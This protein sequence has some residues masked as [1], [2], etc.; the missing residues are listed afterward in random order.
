MSQT[1]FLSSLPSIFKRRGL[2]AACILIATVASA[3]WFA[4]ETP[5]QYEATSRLILDD[6]KSS[7]SELGREL[8]ELTEFGGSVDPIATQAELVVSQRVL[9]L[10]H[11]SLEAAG[12]PDAAQQFPA[13]LVRKNLEVSILPATNILKLTF[14]GSDPESTTL[15]L[16]SLAAAV[17]EEN[18]ETTRSQAAKVRQFL[19]DRIPKLRTQLEDLQQSEQSYRQQTGLVSLPEQTE[20]LIDSLAEL[21]NQDRLLAAQLEETSS[22]ID[23]LRQVTAVSSLEEAYATV[24]AG[25]DEGLARLRAQ[26]TELEVLNIESRS[27]LGDR[28]P[29]LLAIQDQLTDV[30]QQY[31]D[32][33]LGQLPPSM[34]P[35]DGDSEASDDSQAPVPA[36]SLAS[37]ELSQRL[38]SD[39]ILSEIEFSALNERLRRLRSEQGRVQGL[40]AE[41]PE[42]QQAL[43][44]LLR[45]QEETSTSLKLLQS[46]LEEARIAEAQLVSLVR[47]I[48]NARGPAEQSWPNLPVILVLATASGLLLAAGTIL[49]LELLDDKVYD[50]EE[51]RALSD[52]PILGSTPQLALRGSDTARYLLHNQGRVEA[53]RRVIKNIEC[54]TRKAANCIVVSNIQTEK[55]AEP[56][57]AASLAVVAA[58]LSRKTLLIDANLRQST[59]H[60]LLGLAA[61]PGTTEAVNVGLKLAQATQLTS[62]KNLFFLAAGEPS[63]NPSALIESKA[64]QDLIA[65]ASTQFDW[66]IVNT[67]SGEWSDAMTLGQHSDGVALVVAPKVTSRNRLKTVTAELQ[68][69]NIPLLGI[70]VSTGKLRRSVDYPSRD[71]RA[72]PN[73]PTPYPA[74]LN[75]EPSNNS[76]ATS[77]K[78]IC[79]DRPVEAATLDRLS[80]TDLEARLAVLEQSI[81]KIRP[82]VRDQEEELK[83]HQ[84]GI[85]ELERC[86]RAADASKRPS[87]VRELEEERERYRLLEETLLGQRQTLKVREE[88][89]AQHQQALQQRQQKPSPLTPQLMAPKVSNSTC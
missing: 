51:I 86:L 6:R 48:D 1:F 57:L 39:F 68:A 27:R 16:N 49:I 47:V 21:Q 40:L 14:T 79:L 20:S 33:L 29:D 74:P 11:A 3:A 37:D 30:R 50:L 34:A 22:R 41:L 70:V 42:Q 54:S 45:Q 8:T 63:P 75:A 35:L 10:T 53:Y 66:V 2:P 62:I 32:R 36:V 84:R 81:R 60:K 73:K 85:E 26:L 5:P 58:S 52:L 69:N 76:L 77:A 43:A 65:E 89:L 38:I 23:S 44:R 15:F 72:L 46:K 4:R 25:Q 28:H 78:I 88:V 67:A 56:A 31:L 19:E 9:E 24:R 82:F 18:A 17:V 55:S 64:M 7:I 83:L 87:I 59:Q 13:K 61:S 71:R 12:I 80:D